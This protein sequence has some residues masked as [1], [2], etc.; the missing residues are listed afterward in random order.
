MKPL[1]IFEAKLKRDN[2]FGPEVIVISG[3]Q[4]LNVGCRIALL[5]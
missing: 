2:D 3:G 5:S 4:H 1:E